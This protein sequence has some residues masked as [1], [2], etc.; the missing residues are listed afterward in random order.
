MHQDASQHELRH[1]KRYELED[2]VVVTPE[3]VCQLND[4]SEGGLSFKCLYLQNLPDTWTIDLLNTSGTH[5]HN[6]EVEKVWESLDSQK[7]FTNIFAL[8][9]GA[10]F[11]KLSLEQE[12]MLRHLIVSGQA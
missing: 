3:G 7:T 6:I 2:V 4:I 10:R 5:L 1:H 12:G 11:K 8:K 9:V